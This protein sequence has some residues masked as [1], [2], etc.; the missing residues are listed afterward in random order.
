MLH[1]RNARKFE[2]STHSSISSYSEKPFI[3]G[4][5]YRRCFTDCAKAFDCVDHN[6]LCKILKEMG[7]SDHQNWLLQNQY[8]GQYINNLTYIIDVLCISVK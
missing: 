6:K 8:A 7:I 2:H 4:A 1:S 5:S 3:E